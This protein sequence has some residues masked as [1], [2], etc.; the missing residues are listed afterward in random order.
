MWP[1]DCCNTPSLMS[2]P[3]IVTRICAGVFG[4]QAQD[5]GIPSDVWRYYLL[6]SRPEKNDTEFNWDD[7]RLKFT[8]DLNDNLGNFAMRVFKFIQDGCVRLVAVFVCVCGVQVVDTTR[9]TPHT[10]KT[11]IPQ[12]TTR[13][14]ASNNNDNIHNSDTFKH[15]CHHHHHQQTTNNVTL[16]T[17]PASMGWCRNQLLRERPV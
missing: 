15:H 14:L 3:R 12:Q 7:F 4:N 6:A 1:P 16:Y 13:T 9:I 10:T 5:T 17:V 8:A 11:T 2:S